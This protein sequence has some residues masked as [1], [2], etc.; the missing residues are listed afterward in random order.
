[1]RDNASVDKC[2]LEFEDSE[3]ALVQSPSGDVIDTSGHVWLLGTEGS[4]SWEGMD[5]IPTTVYN[6]C[7]EYIRYLI[8]NNALTYVRGQF[9]FMR[10][11]AD[12]TLTNTMQQ[13]LNSHGALDRAFFEAFKRVTRKTV[14]EGN[15]PHY[16]GGFVRW[17]LW[18][19]DAGFDGFDPDVACEF[20]SLRVGGNAIGR[21]VLSHDI[22][23]G[24]LREVEM[25]QLRSALKAAQVNDSLDLAD[26][27][28]TWMLVS[29][30]TNPRNLTLLEEQDYIR[31]ELDDGQ[32]IH[33]IRI[34]RIKK[35]TADERGQFRVRRMIPEIGELV[36]KL[37]AR[38]Q[39]ETHITGAIRPLFRT[40]AP[41]RSLVGTPFEHKAFRM[42]RAGVHN[43]L[44]RVSRTRYGCRLRWA[45]F[46][47]FQGRQRQTAT[48]VS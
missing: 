3:D 42:P 18:S 5:G 19:T 44:K 6:A 32:I 31:T 45:S 25:T 41:R 13:T 40:S 17:Y 28:L 15:L 47:N 46:Y 48:P 8:R 38:N 23:S 36:A 24:P 14:A 1:M 11:M 29:F 4:I 26:L 9:T 30:G 34:P 22:D 2:D 27:T 16:T 12:D 20:E 10:K 7:Q 37:I 43:V 35:R 33:E 39:N 21:A